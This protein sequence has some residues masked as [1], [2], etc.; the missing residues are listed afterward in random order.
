MKIRCSKEQKLVQ[1]MMPQSLFDE[2][3]KKS[4]TLNISLSG[5]IRVALTQFLYRNFNLNEEK[6]DIGRQG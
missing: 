1:I 2:L 4:L 6:H 5:Y 3:K